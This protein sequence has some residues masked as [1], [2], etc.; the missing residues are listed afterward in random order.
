VVSLQVDLPDRSIRLVGNSGEEGYRTL[1][2]FDGEEALAVIAEGAPDLVLLDLILPRRDGFAVIEAIRGLDGPAS[3]I[4]VIIL[5]G[6]TPTP[7]YLERAAS[8]DTTGF[9]TKPVPL[10]HLVEVVASA[11]QEGKPGVPVAEPKA[12]PGARNSGHPPLQ[13][14]LQRMSFP[15]LLH[16]LHGLRATGVLHLERG[17]KRKWIELR[18]GHSVA[19]RSN[20]LNECLGHYLLRK[21]RIHQT[22]LDESRRHMKGGRL[23]GEI[24][25]AME[26]VSEEEITE[27]LR[28]QADEKLFEVFAWDDG[29]FRFDKGSALARANAI[30]VQRS[31]ANLILHGV[32]TRFSGERI[33]AYFHSHADCVVAPGDSPYYRFQEIDLEP[34]QEKL[35]RE[36]D[37]S[38]RVSE[39]LA[40][41]RDQSLAR[42]LYALVATGLLTL[43]GGPVQGARRPAGPQRAPRD[44][45]PEPASE[46]DCASLKAMAERFSAQTYFEILGVGHH[47][48]DTEIAHAFVTLAESSHPDRFSGSSEAV[49]QVAEEVFAHITRAYETLKDPRR[50]GEYV[51]EKRREQREAA[52][53]EQGQRA[54]EA[55]NAFHRGEALLNSRAYEEALAH[56][57]R[58][59]E[60]NPDEGDYHTHY[61]WTLHLCHP[62][63]PP[64]IE[65]AMEH[66]RRG[67]KLASHGDRAYLYMGRLFRAI[68]KPAAAEK[69]FTRAVQLQPDCV[70]ALRE[71]RLINMRRERSRGLIRRMLRR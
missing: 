34:E 61:G 52:K 14:S 59:L 16:H 10:A 46:A 18:D 12:A 37:G 62:S 19:V 42:T 68:G 57:G 60:L 11:L 5:S 49:R 63:D 31:P 8:L 30:G 33:Q 54:L 44:A 51:L 65:E 38:R 56:F 20:L 67:L 40:G 21:G 55:A 25:V 32:R 36:L 70:E 26:L 29:K 9:L 66:V 13:G 23:Q 24:L 43:H 53:E 39:I 64:I 58:A 41:D 1:T 7:E 22:D 69:M 71:L 6:C 45:G 15:T 17:K 48:T 47:A 4:R 27:A 35:L 2:A 50:R 3:A 28:A